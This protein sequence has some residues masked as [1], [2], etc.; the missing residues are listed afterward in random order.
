MDAF[1]GMDGS[2]LPVEICQTRALPP[3]LTL[4]DAASKIKEAVEQLKLN[5]PRSRSG[6]LR[7]QVNVLN[8]PKT[9]IWLMGVLVWTP[10]CILS[11]HFLGCGQI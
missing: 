11:P 1:L 8:Q 4:L 3:S 9:M 10:S 5:P 2:D 6:F 7:F